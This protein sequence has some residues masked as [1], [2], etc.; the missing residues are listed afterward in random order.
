MRSGDVTTVAHALSGA[1]KEAVRIHDA[2]ID[3]VK[4]WMDARTK[5]ASVTDP[6]QLT[7]LD[8]RRKLEEAIRKQDQAA[9]GAILKIAAKMSTAQSQPG[10]TGTP[11]PKAAVVASQG[12]TIKQTPLNQ[13]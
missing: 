2:I 8:L 1:V 9:M 6:P 4:Q 3:I 11:T 13:A 10:G 7:F 5:A 12:S